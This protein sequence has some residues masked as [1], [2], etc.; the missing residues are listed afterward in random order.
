MVLVKV[1]VMLMS[2]S[3]TNEQET[4]EI[5]EFGKDWA[6]DRAKIGTKEGKDNEI[7]EE[8][9]NERY[10]EGNTERQRCE[11]SVGMILVHY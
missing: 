5:S 7:V 2:R 9:Q 11:A 3:S 1:D 8:I 6:W 4:V 10:T